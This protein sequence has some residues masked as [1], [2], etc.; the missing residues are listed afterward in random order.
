MGCLTVVLIISMIYELVWCHS[1]IRETDSLCSPHLVS[2][3]SPV[4][5]PQNNC[6]LMGEEEGLGRGVSMRGIRARGGRIEGLSG[7]WVTVNRGDD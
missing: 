5:A 2:S 6:V 3:P 1:A 7:R 4:S